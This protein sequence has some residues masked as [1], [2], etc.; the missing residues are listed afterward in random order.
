MRW[1]HSPK[2][3]LWANGQSRNTED[4][5]PNNGTPDDK[6]KAIIPRYTVDWDTP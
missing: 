6:K 2:F 4:T 5:V 3:R 1:F